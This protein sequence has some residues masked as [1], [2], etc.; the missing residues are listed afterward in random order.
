MTGDWVL[1]HPHDNVEPFRFWLE[2]Q[3]ALKATK[4]RDGRKRKPA[5]RAADGPSRRIR[6]KRSTVMSARDAA[7][8][9]ADGSGAREAPEE[10]EFA[11]Y[12]PDFAL[13]GHSQAQEEPE[14]P[15]E[16]VLLFGED[17]DLLDA[18]LEADYADEM[19]RNM[20]ADS[21]EIGVEGEGGAVESTGGDPSAAAV[22]PDSEASG[23]EGPLSGEPAA[24][25]LMHGEAGLVD[26]APRANLRARQGAEAS[27]SDHPAAPSGRE[28]ARPGH[29]ILPDVSVAHGSAGD[30]RYNPL[31]E[32][33]IAVC[34]QPG[35]GDCRRSRTCRAAKTLTER[36]AGQGRP[37]GLLT[38]W[39]DTGSRHGTADGHKANITKITREDRL[40]ARAAFQAQPDAQL[41]TVFERDRREGEAEEPLAIA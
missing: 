13:D 30:I 25:N 1:V 17:P 11:E 21:T 35:H 4:P 15:D 31:S 10:D 9:D 39:L 38:A 19:L 28:R 20:D 26:H 22:V 34:K 27:G 24:E 12:V 37:L 6:T 7:A 23:R 5:A 16:E 14:E 8:N 29:S 3:R 2:E 36:S 32:S 40:R 18:G 41:V 33:F